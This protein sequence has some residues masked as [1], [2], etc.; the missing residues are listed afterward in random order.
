[1]KPTSLREQVDALEY[2]YII[3]ALNQSKG[4]YA[5]A[6]RLLKLKISAFK[7]RLKKHGILTS[8]SN[9]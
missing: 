7:Y 1:M 2:H 3:L 4:N 5:A 6:A 9:V 8:S